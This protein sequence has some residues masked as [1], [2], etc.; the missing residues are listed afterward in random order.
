MP[1]HEATYATSVFT[2][3][4]EDFG[5]DF[6]R[7]FEPVAS[8]DGLPIV[9][10]DGERPRVHLDELAP[11]VTPGE[12]GNAP[13]HVRHRMDL[14]AALIR[15]VE[16]SDPERPFPV[17]DVRWAA[18]PDERTM[19]VTIQYSA[20]GRNFSGVDAL[21]EMVGAQFRAAFDPERAPARGGGPKP[22]SS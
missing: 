18:D 20:P 2:F 4:P 5:I 11:G 19:Q 6:D 10:D 12:R 21:G 22:S 16:R 1:E 13:V 3:D 15:N 14:A 17:R 7:L 8:Y 9:D